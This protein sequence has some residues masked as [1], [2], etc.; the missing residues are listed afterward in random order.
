MLAVKTLPALQS[1]LDIVDA[2]AIE[3]RVCL[4][5][6]HSQGITDTSLL[7]MLVSIRSDR[8]V[9]LLAVEMFLDL[10]LH[11]IKVCLN[12]DHACHR[13]TLRASIICQYLSCQKV[14]RPRPKDDLARH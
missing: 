5:W 10:Q 9:T 3:L 13:G 4:P 6:K 14:L 12:S 2:I 8:E 11:T 7:T 1:Y